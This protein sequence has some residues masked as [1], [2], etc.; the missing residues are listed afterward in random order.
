[1]DTQREKKL[2]PCPFCGTKQGDKTKGGFDI[3]TILHSKYDCYT[4]QCGNCW[5]SSGPHDTEKKAI[6]AWNR[7]T[8]E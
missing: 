3:I 5:G 8:E 2:K 1:M 4:V 6:K 7:R